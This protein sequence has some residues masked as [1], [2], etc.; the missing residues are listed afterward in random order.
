MF[1]KRLMVGADLGDFVLELVEGL[2][3]E[4]PRVGG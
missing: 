2:D 3:L 1:S 4:G